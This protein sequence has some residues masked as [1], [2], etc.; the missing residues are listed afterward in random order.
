MENNLST[1]AKLAVSLRP[2]FSFGWRMLLMLTVCRIIFVAWQWQRVI[3]ADML[4]SVFIQGVRFD[5]LLLGLMLTIPVL[6]FPILASNRFLVPAWRGLLKV[7]L[8][9]A[10]LV[11]VFMECSTPSFVDQFDSR[12]NILFLEYL[13]HPREVGATLWAAYKLPIV[14]AVL[15]VTTVT[16]VNS[17]QIGRLVAPVRPT[18]V[19]PAILVTPFLLFICLGLIRSTLDHRPVNPSTVALSSDPLVNDLAL[20]SAYIVSYA[21][22]ETRHEPEGGFRYAEIE[23]ND[24]VTQ[25]RQSMLIAPEAF[26]SS[27]LPTLHRQELSE[28][29]ADHKNLVI[30]VEESLGA[31]FVGSL[32]DLELTPNLDALAGQGMW[33]S[34][35][36]ATAYKNPLYR[37]A[38]AGD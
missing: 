2:L 6:C 27:S 18:G 9:A 35:L 25:V 20:N 26:T 10:L 34:N 13:V 1:T 14:L 29:T 21:A 3:D 31:E 36:Y 12:P 38:A 5:L 32:N 22:Y 23:D 19:A 16:L 11:I 30:I 4:G 33:F 24:I 8:P 7:C 37:L 17:R 28:A 15:F